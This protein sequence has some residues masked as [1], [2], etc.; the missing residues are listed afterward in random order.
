MWSFNYSED[1]YTITYGDDVENEQRMISHIN[2]FVAVIE[3][4]VI[5]VP[6]EVFQKQ[7]IAM[8]NFQK[9]TSWNDK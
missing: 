1:D 5:I 7:K 4:S 2:K 9:T 8:K 3:E 6:F